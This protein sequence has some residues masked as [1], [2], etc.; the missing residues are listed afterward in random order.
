M[1]WKGKRERQR[2][3]V[4]LKFLRKAEEVT[5]VD[6][7]ALVRNR[8]SLSIKI[9]EKE[10]YTGTDAIRLVSLVKQRLVNLF[11][12][13]AYIFSMKDE[14]KKLHKMGH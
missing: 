13:S 1:I 11:S 4:G 8:E 3:H 6:G 10:Y 9:G 2:I 7:L 14:L 12:L 5:K